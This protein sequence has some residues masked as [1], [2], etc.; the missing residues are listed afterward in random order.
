MRG[1]GRPRRGQCSPALRSVQGRGA[2]RLIAARPVGVHF[3]SGREVPLRAAGGQEGEHLR[4]SPSCQSS[5][6]PSGRAARVKL[7]DAFHL[8]TN[9]C[10]DR[11][12]IGCHP[13]GVRRTPRTRTAPGRSVAFTETVSISL[14]SPALPPPGSG[15]KTKLSRHYRKSNFSTVCGQNL[16]AV[17]GT[18]DRPMAGV[19]DKRGQ[20]PLLPA[21]RPRRPHS[22][23]WSTGT[24][25]R[26]L[27]RK[28]KRKDHLPM[29]NGLFVSFL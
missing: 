11:Q 2:G 17:A 16:F 18:R 10:C 1:G 20:G 26:L 4:F 5:P 28:G 3:P 15:A 29:E 7:G 23:P 13:R 24:S 8:P 14:T 21:R 6:F 27:R 12:G 25:V 19:I 22:R 9:R